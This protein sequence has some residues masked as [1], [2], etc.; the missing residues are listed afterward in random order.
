MG[1]KGVGQ[2]CDFGLRLQFIPAL[3]RVFAQVSRRV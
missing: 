1:L 2:A 3:R